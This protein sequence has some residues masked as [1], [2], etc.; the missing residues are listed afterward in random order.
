[1]GKSII[2]FSA[3]P[4]SWGLKGKTREKARIEYELEGYDR[5]KALLTVDK[6]EMSDYD[7]NLR[8]LHLQERYGQI[9]KSDLEF[10]R[11][12]LKKDHGYFSEKEF[13][14]QYLDLQ[15]KYGQITESEKLRSLANLIEDEN[16]RKLAILELDYKEGKIGELAYNKQSATLKG[17]PWVNVLNMD[18]GSG[19][20]AKEGSFEL[21]WNHIFVEELKKNGY[22]AQSDDAIVNLWFMEVCRNIAMEEFDGTGDFAATSEEN[23]EAYKRFQTPTVANGKKQYK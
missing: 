19:G 15:Y 20:N 17:E 14:A 21:D 2:P 6:D 4:G 5:D 16:S 23:L 3:W 18:F 7:Y 8:L 1:M 22:E 12:E 13:S 9:S 10:K 11:L